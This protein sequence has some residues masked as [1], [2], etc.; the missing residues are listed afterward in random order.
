MTTLSSELK[1]RAIESGF[2]SVGIASPKMLQNLPYGWVRKIRKLNTPEEELECVRSI[3]LLA[4]HSWDNIF[5]M[6]ID[7]PKNSTPGRN[8]ESYYFGTEIM[9]NKAWVLVD[10]LH[11]RG[12]E[13][14][15]SIDIPLKTAAVQCGLG[16]Q[17]KNTL[18]ITPEYGPRV[19]LIAVL[20]DAVLETDSFY[21]GDLCGDCNRCIRVCPTNAIEPYRLNVTRCMVYSCESPD[22]DDVP[23]DVRQA[24][25][26]LFTRPTSNSFIECTRC[27]DVCPIGKEPA[28]VVKDHYGLK[29]GDLEWHLY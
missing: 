1:E 15:W 26:R 18:L 14:I 8:L 13:A 24:E 10:F 7:P 20:T 21:E 28:I 16:I 6:N 19:K 17:G 9:K 23:E 2:V 25:K 29:F 22:S 5:S 12:F 11:Q 4:W 3:I 27:I